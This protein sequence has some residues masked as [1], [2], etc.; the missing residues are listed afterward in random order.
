VRAE[1][2]LLGRAHGGLDRLALEAMVNP[3][4]Q[5]RLREVLG[6]RSN[7]PAFVLEDVHDPHNISAVLRTLEG[8]GLHRVFV[9]ESTTGFEVN[10]QVT[11]GADKWLDIRRYGT[12]KACVNELRGL[13]YQLLTTR[14]D[15][16]LTLDELDFSRPTA[17]I[18]GN[19]RDGISPELDGL[20]DHAFRI[21]MD[22][23]SQSFNV[24]VAAALI[25]RTAALRLSEH[26]ERRAP[27]SEDELEQRYLDYLWYSV[28]QRERIEVATGSVADDSSPG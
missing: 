5:A 8:L 25:A 6:R 9:I 28:K 4:R 24:S 27:L 11:Q 2:A 20:A 19:E 12:A 16:T 3:A 22:G 17:I 23:F 7:N 26:P 1:P 14:M 21:P 13:G 18:M 10:P 15:A